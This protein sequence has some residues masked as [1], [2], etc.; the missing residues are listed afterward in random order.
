MIFK[1]DDESHQTQLATWTKSPKWKDTITF[2]KLQPTSK[3]SVKLVEKSGG[4]E[5]D[6]VHMDEFWDISSLKPKQ[7]DTHEIIKFKSLVKDCYKEKMFTITMAYETIGADDVGSVAQKAAASAKVGFLPE[8]KET[9]TDTKFFNA[10]VQCDMDTIKELLPTITSMNMCRDYNTPLHVCAE[11]KK[12]GSAAIA[13]FLLDNGAMINAFYTRGGGG[14]TPLHRAALENN[15]EVAKVLVNRGA[16]KTIRANSEK[17]FDEYGNA[18][19][20]ALK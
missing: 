7:T 10:I 2:T 8:H 6:F 14:M 16:D 9:P 3:I 13:E 15:V 20:K 17:T 5:A 18:E 4:V 19:I 11:T 12:P 1:L